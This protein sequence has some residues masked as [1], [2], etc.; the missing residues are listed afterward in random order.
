MRPIGPVLTLDLS[1]RVDR[2]ALDLQWEGAVGVLGL[3]GPSGSGKTTVLE[4]IAGLRHPTRGRVVLGSHVLLDTAAR[5]TIPPRLRGIG[6][7]PQD[8]ALFPHLSVRRNVLYG[9][10]RAVHA[11]LDAVLAMLEV[12][13]L[14]DRE[15][16]GLSGG[17]RQRIALARAL[18]SGPSLLLLDEPL[19]AVDVARRHRIL[20]R[21]IAWLH[22]TGLP[23]VH[24]SH[25]ASELESAD[26]TLVLGD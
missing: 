15:I 20:T 12:E 16:A 26:H 1:V 23:A 9:E 24:V 14:I 13:A 7:A 19:S 11:P 25:D 2:F 3:F 8:A 10:G 6:Y 18:L 17:E 4:V 5:T 21:L 22:E